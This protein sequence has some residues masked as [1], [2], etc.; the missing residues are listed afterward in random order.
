MELDIL[1][2]ILLISVLSFNVTN[3]EQKRPNFVL[4]NMDDVSTKNFSS[5]KST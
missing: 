5:K 2:I 1:V 3:A 4:M